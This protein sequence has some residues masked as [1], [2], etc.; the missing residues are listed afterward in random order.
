MSFQRTRNWE[1]SSNCTRHTCRRGSTWGHRERPW[2][3]G[4]GSEGSEGTGQ[5]E[6]TGQG[7]KRGHRMGL[8]EGSTCGEEGEE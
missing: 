7:S 3:T 4:Q 1:S 2:G 8:M 5:R 6:V